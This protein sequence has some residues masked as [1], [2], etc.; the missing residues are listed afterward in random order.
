MGS[1][2]I[3]SD[4]FY[5]LNIY[6]P[7]SSSFLK[8]ILKK[9][10]I[11]SARLA[12]GTPHPIK[13]LLEGITQLLCVCYKIGIFNDCRVVGFLVCVI[14]F[15]FSYQPYKSLSLSLSFSVFLALLGFITAI[16]SLSR[17]LSRYNCSNYQS[18]VFLLLLL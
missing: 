12:P 2:V 6:S 13:L 17:E 18:F 10:Y 15:F 3:E 5:Y 1:D 7:S 14:S 11:R 16:F 4:M 8:K 9:D